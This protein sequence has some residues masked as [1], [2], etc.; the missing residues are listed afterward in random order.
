MIYGYIR[1]STN[2]QDTAAQKIGVEKKAAELGV[3][4]NEWIKDDGVSGIKE[5]SKRNLGVLMEKIKDGDVIIVPEISRLAR[6]VFMLFRIVEHCT[7]KMNATIYACKEGQVFRKDDVVS[8]IL[9]SAYGTAA[10]IERE[11]ICK[12]TRE[13]MERSRLK[14]V[15]FGPRIGY[16]KK[17]KLAKH[18][19]K[20]LAY[21]DKGYSNAKIAKL[22]GCAKITLL[23]Y[24]ARMGIKGNKNKYENYRR[25]KNYISFVA[26]QKTMDKNKPIVL[27][28]IGKGIR[29]PRKIFAGLVE[30]GIEVSRS[31]VTR[32]FSLHPDVYAIAIEKDRALRAIHNPPQRYCFSA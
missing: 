25:T 2:K 27:K 5:Y 17:L 9:L 20:I 26:G 12:R 14:G 4:I 21:I 10:Q 11:M 29:S 18:H 6:S 28:M 23:D 13:G 24:L 8:A 1:V 19:N 3:N 22:C 16:R 32:W 31:T 7:Q 30:K 15:I